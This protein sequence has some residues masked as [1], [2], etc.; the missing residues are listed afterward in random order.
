MKTLLA[1]ALPSLLTLCPSAHALALNLL[2]VTSSDSAFPPSSNLTL[3]VGPNQHC[4]KDPT[5]LIPAFPDIRWYQTTCQNALFKA[6]KDLASFGLD[7]EFEFLTRGAIPQTTKPQI[8]LP[9]KYVA[10]KYDVLTRKPRLNKQLDHAQE[11]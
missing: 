4:T 11:I 3:G 9:R 8:Q 6:D 7:T 5:W 10:S 1:L 2:N